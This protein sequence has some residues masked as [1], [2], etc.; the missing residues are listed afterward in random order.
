VCAG[1]KTTGITAYP[2]QNPPLPPAATCCD[3]KQEP[4]TNGNLPCLQGHQKCCLTG[5]WACPNQVNFYSCGGQWIPETGTFGSP[6]SAA[7]LID[8]GSDGATDVRAV[9]PSRDRS[10][11]EPQDN[12]V[13][14]QASFLAQPDLPPA[15]RCCDPSQEPGKNGNPICFEGYKCCITGEWACASG[16]GNSFLCGG[17][18]TPS[19]GTFGFPCP[20]LPPAAVCCDALKEPGKYGNSICPMVINAV[21]RENGLVRMR[22]E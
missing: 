2:C 6:C 19:T 15:A 5:E 13:P 21:L 1:S 14:V 8:T 17:Q 7:A 11:S 20:E 4:G 18:W 12:N 10:T 16:G 9:V 3:P 22:M